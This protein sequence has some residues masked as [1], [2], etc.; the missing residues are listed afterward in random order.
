MVRSPGCRGC[1]SHG[2]RFAWA[3]PLWRPGRRGHDGNVCE[4][5]ACCVINHLD[6]KNAS[7]LLLALSLAR[8]L[9]RLLSRVVARSLDRS[10][11][12]YLFALSL[13]S[14]NCG[15]S[16]VAEASRNQLLINY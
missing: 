4:S 6:I 16:W 13:A 1:G 2:G 15:L 12:A 11:D 8:S 7:C 5:A 3:W 10:L 14:R 9:A